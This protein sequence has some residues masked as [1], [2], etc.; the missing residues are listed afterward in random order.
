MRPPRA[1]RLA[2]P[3]ERSKKHGGLREADAHGHAPARRRQE[4]AGVKTVA[5]PLG[6]L[7]ERV[8]GVGARHKTQLPGRR[9]RQAGPP[10]AWFIDAEPVFRGAGLVGLVFEE[11]PGR[12]P[13]AR[14]RQ[15]KGRAAVPGRVRARRPRAAQADAPGDF[16]RRRGRG[17]DER[18]RLYGP[19]D[20]RRGPLEPA[21]GE[22]AQARQRAVDARA[23]GQL[24][25]LP[26]PA[27]HA[28]QRHG[29][30][31]AQFTISVVPRGR[32]P[33][34]AA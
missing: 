5:G 28:R 33:D 27:A 4:A 26:L 1:R 22:A 3:R 16:E 34:L 32:G 30:L 25:P 14:I 2:R 20:L 13:E 10:A 9:H 15:K 24:Q 29:Q 12:R 21:G 6:E 23:D 7:P 18:R 11:D 19:R 31:L 8:H 17:L